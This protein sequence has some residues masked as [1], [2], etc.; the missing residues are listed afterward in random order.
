MTRPPFI[1]QSDAGYGD[2]RN[3]NEVNVALTRALEARGWKYTR[4]KFDFGT[5]KPAKPAESPKQPR[6]IKT[7]EQRAQSLR[8][9]SRR[10][11]DGLKAKGVCLHC[12]KPSRPG[13]TLCG[14]C[15][16]KKYVAKRSAMEATR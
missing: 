12:R 6:T 3:L 5:R 8:D 16:A 7:P 2:V 11:K 1:Q 9:A 14:A 15:A 4:S 10:Y 13:F